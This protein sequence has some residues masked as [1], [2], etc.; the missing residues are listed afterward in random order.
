MERPVRPAPLAAILAAG[1]CAA[2]IAGF[3]AAF[4]VFS[5]LEHP[6]GLLGA[7]RV[8]R[9]AAFNLLGFVLPGLLAAAAAWMVRARLGRASWAARIGLQALL[10]SGLAFAAQGLL[11]LDSDD[12]D[13]AASRLHAAAWTLWWVAYGTGALAF[14]LGARDAASR[15]TAN[16]LAGFA[17]ATLVFA[18]LAPA[19]LP[20]GLS[21][22]I[23]YAGWFVG[24]WWL[25]RRQP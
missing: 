6:A 5:H 11:P 1:L 12:L 24:L 8:P 15:A 22:R 4:P 9:A 18:L 13:A 10:L 3:G 25:A 16:L 20:P 19:V 7:S 23:A 21:Q 17:A 2:A 14:R